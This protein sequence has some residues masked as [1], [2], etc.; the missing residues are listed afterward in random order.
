MPPYTLRGLTRWVGTGRGL[1]QTGRIRLADAKGL[2]EL[3]QTGDMIDRK[4]GDRVFRT[5]TSDEL[6]G[7]TLAVSWAK[8]AG[9]VRVVKGR[10][11]PV[12]KGQALLDRPLDLWDRA[13]DAFPSLGAVVCPSGWGESLLHREFEP[14]IRAVLT[15]L[16]GAPL[17]LSE[18]CDLTWEM[19]SFRYVIQHGEDLLRR[20][21]DR[22]T[23]LAIA[24]LEALGAVHIDR[25]SQA[26][27]LELTG[28]GLRAL[29]R[30]LSEAGPGEP[31]CQVKV[32][33]L[34]VDDPPVWRRLLVSAGVRLDRLHRILQAAMGWED[35]HLHVF[36]AG[37]H[38][39]GDPDPELD[40]EDERAVRLADLAGTR[41]ARIGYTYDFG[42]SWEHAIVVENLLAAE[43]PVRYPVCVAGEGACPPE[44]CGGVPGYWRMRE[45]LADPD[46]PEHE[47]LRTW[48]G[49]DEGGLAFDPSRFDLGHV[50]RALKA[51][52]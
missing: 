31:I 27:H 41:R 13:F 32:S 40:F 35:S 3:L 8:A 52:C 48:L 5:T 28:L 37:D 16:Y 4:T 18:A 39:Y 7:L 15:R 36:S 34:G 29:R 6:P 24:A 25:A 19:A 30:L 1:T 23:G 9:L 21:N 12:K 26:A 14:A 44:D 11:V 20:E 38:R 42:D 47:E 43:E 22:D 33:L 45:V 51:I 49:L 46:D 17:L 2:V 50:N 10:L